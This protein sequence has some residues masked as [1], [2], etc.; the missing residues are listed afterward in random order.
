MVSSMGVEELKKYLR[1][2]G[3][4]VTGRKQELVAR[5]FAAVENGV[6][7]VKSAVEIEKEIRTEYDSKLKVDDIIIPDPY[8][9]T[10]GWVDEKYGMKFWPMVLYP[11]IF[12]YLMFFPSELGSKDL[13]DYKNSKAYSYYKSGW[14]GQLWYHCIDGSG[15]FCVLKTDCRKS[16]SIRDTNHKLWIVIEKK[17][18]HIRSCHCT[19]MAGMSETCNHVAAAM[20]RIEAA[21]RTGLTNPACTST[22]NQWLPTHL[23]KHYVMALRSYYSF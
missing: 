4:R 19:C 10:E 16:Q 13:N 23:K 18:A 21:V 2:R 8:T 5:V 6:E 9:L 12:N 22:E 17:S 1:L 15:K 14:L 11:D 3:L 20:F 7:P